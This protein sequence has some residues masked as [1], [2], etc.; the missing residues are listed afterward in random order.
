MPPRDA[1][2]LPTTTDRRRILDVVFALSVLLIIGPLLFTILVASDLSLAAKI[3][4][5]AAG[6]FVYT[7]L[8][9]IALIAGGSVPAP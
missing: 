8:P 1:L 3:V 2:R 5:G 7:C 9:Y 6:L 4:I